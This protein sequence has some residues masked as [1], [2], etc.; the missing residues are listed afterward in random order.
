VCASLGRWLVLSN[1]HSKIKEIGS[2]FFPLDIWFNIFQHIEKVLS[3]PIE[4]IPA[5][6]IHLHPPQLILS[7]SLASA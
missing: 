5:G 3:V 4:V 1:G 7:P 2:T 6:Q